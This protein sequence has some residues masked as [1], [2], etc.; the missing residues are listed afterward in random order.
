MTFRERLEKEI[1][2]LDEKVKKLEWFLIEPE[3]DLS[4]EEY[5]LLDMQLSAM[6]TYWKILCLRASKR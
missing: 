4:D 5:A 2:D 3:E 1:L 6:E